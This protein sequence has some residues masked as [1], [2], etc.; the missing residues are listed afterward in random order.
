M[1]AWVEPF[2]GRN[3]DSRAQVAPAMPSTPPH[4]KRRVTFTPHG[5]GVRRFSTNG[6]AF[7]MDTLPQPS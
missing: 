2:T 4:A 6:G 3:D 5:I 7:C 1:A